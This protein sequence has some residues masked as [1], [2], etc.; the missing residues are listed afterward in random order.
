[1]IPPDAARYQRVF[2]STPVLRVH[3]A[4]AGSQGFVT[5]APVDVADR[6]IE[7]ALSHVV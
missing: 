1:M 4:P 7:R 2:P 3:T 5:T 6:A